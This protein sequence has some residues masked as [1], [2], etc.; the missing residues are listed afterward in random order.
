MVLTRMIFGKWRDDLK[1]HKRNGKFLGV[2]EL[3]HE[4]RYYHSHT[5]KLS[6]EVEKH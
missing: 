4:Q 6:D 5:Q 2:T 1:P 3:F